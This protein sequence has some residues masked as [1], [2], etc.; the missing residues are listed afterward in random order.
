MYISLLDPGLR[1][2]Y[3][4]AYK[5]TRSWIVAY[6]YIY[7]IS[8]LDPGFRRKYMYVY[9][10]PRSWF[11]AYILQQSTCKVWNTVLNNKCT[12]LTLLVRHL[13]ILVNYL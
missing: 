9:K 6:I 5:F 2:K 13:Q 10:F 7:D 12:F 4:Y 3:M 11:V 1:R 8:L